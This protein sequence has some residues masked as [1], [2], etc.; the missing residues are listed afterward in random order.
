[1]SL[2]AF[3]D[4]FLSALVYN[5]EVAVFDTARLSRPLPA[6][7]ASAGGD[8][9]PKQMNFAENSPIRGSVNPLP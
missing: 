4:E 7:W 6:L 3:I 5:P 2:R 1:M 8:R 9:S